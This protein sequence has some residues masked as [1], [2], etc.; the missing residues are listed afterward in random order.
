[1]SPVLFAWWA[2]GEKWRFVLKMDRIN[3]TG[4]GCSNSPSFY[5]GSTIAP[6][7]SYP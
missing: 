6:R 7:E 4:E 2:F 3:T 5:L 1:M